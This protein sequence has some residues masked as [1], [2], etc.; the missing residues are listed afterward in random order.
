MKFRYQV[1]GH[2]ASFIALSDQTQNGTVTCGTYQLFMGKSNK[3]YFLWE[4]PIN[5]TIFK[6]FVKSHNRSQSKK[7][8]LQ[9]FAQFQMGVLFEV[10][11][12]F[13]VP[14]EIKCWYDNNIQSQQKK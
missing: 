9:S 8:K 3:S 6:N 10:I 11:T 2:S 1:L 14:S 7:R 4:M 13:M 5:P 12:C